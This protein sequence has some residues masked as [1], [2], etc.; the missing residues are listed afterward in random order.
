MN[1]QIIL[2]IRVTDRQA[3]TTAAVQ[4]VLTK[5]GCS[6]GTR[7]GLHDPSTGTQ[8]GNGLIL[9]DVCGT[10]EEAMKLENELLK[11]DGIQVR[12]MIFEP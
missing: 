11:I 5:F 3:G 12:K 10:R 4:S 9:L 6:I 2:G 7:L 8:A 1:E